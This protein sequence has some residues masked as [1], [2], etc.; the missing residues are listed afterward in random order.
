MVWSLSVL[1]SK[2][3]SFCK[4]YTILHGVAWRCDRLLMQTI[5]I[6][7]RGTWLKGVIDGRSRGANRSTSILRLNA[8]T[9][10]SLGKKSASAFCNTLSAFT[11]LEMDHVYGCRLGSLNAGR[12]F[13]SS[14]ERKSSLKSLISP[15]TIRRPKSFR[16]RSRCQLPNQANMT[17]SCDPP[18]FTIALHISRLLR[19][20]QKFG[21][22]QA[23]LNDYVNIYLQSGLN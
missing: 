23:V 14:F 9:I 2:G 11:Y 7:V 8:L 1:R 16:P 6:V 19:I 4:I 15:D 18:H 12:K 22:H 10:T 21:L 5:S 13:N 20:K 3:Y 17:T